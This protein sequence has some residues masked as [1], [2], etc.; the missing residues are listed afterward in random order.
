MYGGYPPV[1]GGYY[2]PPYAAYGGPY[3]GYYGS[4]CVTDNGYGRFSS[5]R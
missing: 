4:G 5:C 1:Y 2:P 3:G